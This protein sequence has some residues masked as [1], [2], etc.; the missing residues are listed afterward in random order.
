MMEKP[1]T[2]VRLKDFEIESIK[3]SFNKC[4][5]PTDHLWIFGSRTNPNRR[6]G[7]IDLY[8]ETT[9]EP[10]LLFETKL[11]FINAICELIGDQR[12]DVVLNTIQN[13]LNLPIYTKARTEGVQLV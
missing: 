12:I 9:L 4:F 2:K 7:D 6:G 8:V 3:Q 5:L 13:S 11:A 1:T 10:S